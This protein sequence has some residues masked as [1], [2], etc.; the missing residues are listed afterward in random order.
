M[1]ESGFRIGYRIAYIVITRHY[2]KKLYIKDPE[3]RD[4]IT[5]VE[6]IN[7]IGR[8]ILPLLILRGASVLDK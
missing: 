6:Y 5:S 8:V 7:L 4:F 1:D 2:C 3:Y